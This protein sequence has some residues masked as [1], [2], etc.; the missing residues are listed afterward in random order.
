MNSMINEGK[1][2]EWSVKEE[3][4]REKVEE[5]YIY[6]EKMRFNEKILL[7]L[8]ESCYLERYLWKYMNDESTDNH[9]YSI[10][11]LSVYKKSSGKPWDFIS[12]KPSFFSFFFKRVLEHAFLDS[13]KA[14]LRTYL[15]SFIIISFQLFDNDVI[16]KECTSLISI[17]IWANLSSK[18]TIKSRISMHPH[19][20]KQWKASVKKFNSSYNET[21]LKK[22]FYRDWLFN[23][24]I[25]FINLLYNVKNNEHLIYCEKV[26]ELLIDLLSQPLSR[27]YLNFLLK[28]F[29]FTALVKKSPMYMI[30]ENYVF[31]SLFSILDEYIYIG[32]DDH[33][34]VELSSEKITE[35]HYNKIA[36]LQRIAMKEYKEKLIILATSNYATIDTGDTLIEHLEGLD[37]NEFYELFQHIGLRSQYPKELLVPIDREFLTLALIEYYK[38]RKSLQEIFEDFLVI[39][40]EKSLFSLKFHFYK[41]YNGI[42][43]LPLLKFNLQYLS[44]NDFIYRSLQFYRD[45]V[46]DE[47]HKDIEQV[48]SRLKPKVQYPSFTIRFQGNSNMALIIKHL[49]IL[50]VSPPKVGEEKPG[51]VRAEV[52]LELDNITEELR[53]QWESLHPGDIVYLLSI[54]PID[55]LK[56]TPEMNVS[57]SLKSGL[58][59]LRIAQVDQILNYD[60]RPLKV[61]EQLAQE[62]EFEMVKTGRKRILRLFLD[63]HNYKIDN[64][65]VLYHNKDDVYAS[66]NVIV[67]R[68]PKET[69]FKLILESLKSLTRTS[70]SLPSW[71]EDIFL[72]FGDP[73]SAL[74]YNLNAPLNLFFPDTFFDWNHLLEC[75]PNKN[76][77]LIP[78]EK[79]N[80]APNP[81]Y[82]IYSGSIPSLENSCELNNGL[83]NK[84]DNVLYVETY[85]FLNPGPYLQNKKK[86]NKIRFTPKQVEAIYSGTNPGL[87]LINGAPG[88]GKADIIAQIICNIYYNFP[89]QRTLLIAHNSQALIKVFEKL[90]LLD[91]PQRHLLRLG[92]EDELEDEF[93]SRRP[94]RINLFLE[95]RASLLLEVDRLA[96]T[97]QI[98]GAHGNSCETAGYFFDFY[99]KPLWTNFISN[100]KNESSVKEIISSFPFHQYFS[101]APQPLFPEDLNKHETLDI[102]KGCY[103]HIKELFSELS[104]IRPFEFLHSN[105]ARSNYL[106]NKAKIIAM[107]SS[108]LLTKREKIF[109]LKFK[110][111]TIIYKNSNQLLE[112]ETFV[113]MTLM[114]NFE[115]LQR[116]V[117]L[118]DYK[119]MGPI[120]KNK[121][122]R[123]FCNAKQ[124]FYDRLIRLGVPIIHLDAQG[125]AKNTIAELFSWAYGGLANLP[126]IEKQ[127][128]FLYSNSGFLF[129]YQ[130]INVGDYKGQGETEPTPYFYQNL[131]EAEYAV[132]IYQYMRLLGY[133]S[134]KI[135]ILASYTGQKA[136]INDVI[137]RRCA[138]NPLFGLPNKI[139]TID[140][141]QESY[142]DYIILSLTRTKSLGYLK[143]LERLIVAVSRARLGLY[144]LGRRSIFESCFELKPIISRVLKNPDKLHLVSQEMWPSNRKIGDKVENTFVMEGV[145]HL[146]I[147]VY[148]MSEKALEKLKENKDIL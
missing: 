39:P 19:L 125:R 128:E 80:S 87:T 148:K 38:R 35:I 60:G 93:I 43:S 139:T 127:S 12:D 67:R 20:Q 116:I 135:T 64:D 68:S 131:G 74:Y 89:D 1:L 46:Y 27:R 71:F 145:E 6:L 75:F 25:D 103:N 4:D 142:N 79:Y 140:Q 144:I 24:I 32:Y 42:R 90:S 132:A 40:D 86:N 147:Y 49:A 72:G 113:P 97:L 55:D 99:V 143:E 123:Y 82:R 10:C 84:S 56:E 95:R 69:N 141:Y 61:V 5:I 73:S 28:D 53:R 106:L 104:D 122:F 77:K 41:K 112:I 57:F 117:L 58:R 52:K 33:N 108:Y 129:D 54:K 18:E 107:T 126:N 62:D 78:S 76:I 65:G 88:T 9:I 138:N 29:H 2:S 3:F 14:I 36:K 130:F 47:I 124:S 109:D 70:I 48:I 45:K 120:L 22:K 15:L 13:K 83:E 137:N 8:E 102:A 101:T 59:Y 16:R 98:P 34:S 37:D 30:S 105:E 26:L 92:H 100:S 31:K 134:E 111:N 7:Y 114:T 94:G 21:L 51:F 44:I 63:T 66:I 91:I 119:Q 118:G 110:Y 115:S 85:N 136:L 17:D 96:L 23:I 50:E 133:P 146:G 121:A 11:I 81:P